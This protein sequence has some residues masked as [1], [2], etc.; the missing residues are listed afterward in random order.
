MIYQGRI[1]G[2]LWYHP[3]EKERTGV[4]T[5]DIPACYVSA[6][7]A[8][9]EKGSV[10]NARTYVSNLEQTLQT[11]CQQDPSTDPTGCASVGTSTATSTS[12]TAPARPAPSTTKAP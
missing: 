3:V 12:T 7:E 10:A 5:A 6:L 4:T 1:G 11:Q 8:G 9:V 2:F